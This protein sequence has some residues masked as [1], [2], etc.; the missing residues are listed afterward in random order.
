MNFFIFASLF[1]FSALLLIISGNIELP[2]GEKVAM[3]P[4]KLAEQIRGN[5]EKK[6]IIAQQKFDLPQTQSAIAAGQ[7]RIYIN[8]PGEEEI[9]QQSPQ[10]EQPKPQKD[11]AAAFTP[12]AWFHALITVFS[13]RD[14]K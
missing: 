2:T 6:A 4:T 3:H 7:Q 11:T 1:V 14:E 13:G 9:V 12:A 5:Q 10:P 8:T